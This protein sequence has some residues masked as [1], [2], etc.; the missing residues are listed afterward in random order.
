MEKLTIKILF[1]GLISLLINLTGCSSSSLTPRYGQKTKDKSITK[2]KFQDTVNINSFRDSMMVSEEISDSLYDLID[3][4]DDPYI[5]VKINKDS[6]IAMLN[7]TGNTTNI[8]ERDKVLFEVI[9]YLD[10]PYHYGGNTKNGL[11][12]SAFT[13]SVYKNSLQMDLPRSSSDQYS[14]GNKISNQ[15]NLK[16]GDLVF[17]KTRRRR[18]VSHVGIYLGERLFA[19]ASSSSGVIISSLDET[20][21]KKR[22]VGARR[23][24]ENI[25]IK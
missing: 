24:V 8:T 7:R 14:V 10:T 25:T 22:Y 17:F 21:Y 1:L 6:V 11:D 18:S 20:Y 15:D 12:C 9:K 13:G 23:I 5:S 2:H 16:F 4:D 19:H 3:I